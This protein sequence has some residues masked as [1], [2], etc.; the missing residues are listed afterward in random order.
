MFSGL[1]MEL[2][3]DSVSISMGIISADNEKAIDMEPTQEWAREGS[4]ESNTSTEYMSM[5]QEKA[6]LW[7]TL[8]P[9][10]FKGYIATT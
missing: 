10:G 9:M 2:R 6:G 7:D 5:W 1:E 4:P 3:L 8:E